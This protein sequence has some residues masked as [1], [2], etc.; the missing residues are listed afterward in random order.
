MSAID[1]HPSLRRRTARRRVV[2]ALLAASALVAAGGCAYFNTL[3]NA[4][5]KYREAM[6]QRTGP[7]GKPSRSQVRMLD[8]AIRKCQTVIG[9]WPDSRHVDDA[10]L[11]IARCL[12]AQQKYLE[13]AAQ[14]DTLE[15]RF[16][17]TD[18]LPQARLLRG[19]ALALA[20]EYEAAIEVLADYAE[21]WSD[22]DD[23]EEACYH[24][25]VCCTRLDRL[26]DAIGWVRRLQDRNARS[27]RT[28]DAQIEVATI[29]GEQGRWT[30]ALAIW[31]QLDAGRLPIDHRYAVWLGRAR[32]ELEAGDPAEAL[33]AAGRLRGLELTSA[34]RPPAELLRARAYEA[35]DSTATAMTVYASVA[36]RFSRG[37]AGAEAHYRLG[38][39]YEA[40]DSLAAARHEYEQVSRAY[41]RSPFATDA[42][43]RAGNIAR[44][45]RLADAKDDTSPEALAL[46]AFTLAELQLTQFE[47]PEQAIE[48]Y[49]TVLE[50]YPRSDLAP[51]AA[52]A[53]AWIYRRVLDDS[54]RAAAALDT[55]VARYPD[56]QQAR[57]A[58]VLL[59]LPTP[60]G[61]ATA[62]AG[63]A[64]A[65]AGGG[66][67]GSGRSGTAPAGADST[68][69]DSTRAGRRRP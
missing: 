60:A 37:A 44:L 4:R 11:L 32:A 55:L 59:R 16:P 30:D 18:L 53:I 62:S 20:G 56:S 46:R 3:Y 63:T 28:L 69:P 25:A 12:Y 48:G 43:R 6:K 52:Y 42:V 5:E 65:S 8:E 38:R 45:L 67:D 66:P 17:D 15:A 9:T 58:A 57:Y 64:A 21:H 14:T 1:R 39:L 47:H 24:L 54:V 41:A 51:R 23:V 34:Q 50:S 2:V 29:L 10:M 61:G 31:R 33:A 13:A 49:R 27:R 26:D 35:L 40:Q 7:D 22:R 19:R 36:R 68:A